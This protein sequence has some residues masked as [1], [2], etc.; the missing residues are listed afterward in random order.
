METVIRVQQYSAL[1][2]CYEAI[3]TDRDEYAMTD[4]RYIYR[5]CSD[6]TRG[7]IVTHANGIDFVEA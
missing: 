6:N 2:G 3:V 1:R 5:R 7:R 4:H